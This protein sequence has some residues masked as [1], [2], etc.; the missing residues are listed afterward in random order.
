MG[1]LTAL[2]VPS[3]RALQST[4]GVYLTTM[5][6]ERSVFDARVAEY[7]SVRDEMIG[8]IANQ[9]LV[10]TF[11]TASTVG[12]FAAGFVEWHQ[13]V[14]PAIF[15]GISPLTWW[16]LVMW[17]SEV[18]RMLRA[19]RFCGDQEV[20]INASLAPTTTGQ[21]L[22]WESWRRSTGGTIISSYVS[23]VAVIALT[24]LCALVCA[25]FAARH[26]PRLSTFWTFTPDVLTVFF[27][28][29]LA[30]WAATA[31]FDHAPPAGMPKVKTLEWLLKLLMPRRRRSERAG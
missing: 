4:S 12:L 8:A 11:G 24:D 10:L 25:Y 27:G 29:L 9:H 16:I 13:R 14:A 22:S 15:F 30:I 18:L 3:G 26:S 1:L 5:D 17:L 31:F 23:V 6:A 21:A 19:V 7:V 28:V 2:R 20:L